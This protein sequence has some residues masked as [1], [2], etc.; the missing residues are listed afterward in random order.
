MVGGFLCCVVLWHEVS[1]N[2]ALAS[3]SFESKV[4]RPISFGVRLVQ[5]NVLIP[6][7]I[8]NCSL[9]VQWSN[10]RW[11]SLQ[12]RGKYW[13]VVCEEWTSVIPNF[14]RP[15][16]WRAPQLLLWTP[17]TKDELGFVCP[18]IPMSVHQCVGRMWISRV[19][20]RKKQSPAPTV[21][22]REQQ[23]KQRRNAANFFVRQLS[24]T[25]YTI[26]HWHCR[27]PVSSSLILAR[28]RFA[29]K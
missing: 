14:P 1:R 11:E 8:S 6:V 18:S 22:W 12:H 19:N 28:L 3:E 2:K 15:Y 21:F 20:N 29:S 13:S 27:Q 4:P 26:F 17:S 23:Q 7:C 5:S 16:G 25:I 9:T 24:T 10:P